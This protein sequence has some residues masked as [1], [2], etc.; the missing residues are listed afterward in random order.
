[1]YSLGRAEY[2]RLGLGDGAEEKTVPTPVPGI[3]GAQVVACGASVSYAATKDGEHH[4]PH[5]P[6]LQYDLSGLKTS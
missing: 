3:E 2:G 1:M 6:D 4:T 5:S